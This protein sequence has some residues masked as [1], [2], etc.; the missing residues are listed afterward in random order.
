[1]T[2]DRDYGEL[3]YKYKLSSPAGVLYFRFIPLYPEEPA[4]LMLRILEQEQVNLQ[5]KFTVVTRTS[6]RQRDLGRMP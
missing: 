4:E 6:V 3:I 1:M 2:F 5:G